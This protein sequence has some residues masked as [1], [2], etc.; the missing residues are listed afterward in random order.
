VLHAERRPEIE[1][2]A[3]IRPGVSLLFVEDDPVIIN[4]FGRMIPAKFPDVEFHMAENG[5][6]GLEFFKKRMP[7]IV[8]TDIRMPV[9][10]GITMVAE[11]KALCPA[12][13]I[14]IV[15]ANCDADYLLNDNDIDHCV[16]KPINYKILFAIIEKCIAGIASQLD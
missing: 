1:T 12:T 13:I 8:I 4:L 10:D 7:Q 9:M 3:G 11:I 14:I 6:I 2:S 15:A 16:S 5:K